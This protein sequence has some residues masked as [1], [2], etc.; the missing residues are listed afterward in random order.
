MDTT[1]ELVRVSAQ[2]IHA[3]AQQREKSLKL[4]E[5]K[6]CAAKQQIP[7]ELVGLYTR[8]ADAYS[9]YLTAFADSKA[10]AEHATEIRY[11]R[12]DILCFKLAKGEEAGDE[13]LAVGK[14]AP[15]GKLHKP[16]LQNAIDAFEAARP[17]DTQGKHQVYP[18][19]EKFGEALDLYATLFPGDP[20]IIGQIYKN[21]QMFFDYGD[22]DNAIKRFGVI[23]TRYPKDENA[24]PAGDKILAALGKAKDFENLETWARKLKTAPSFQS[25]DRQELLTKLIVESIQ[26]SG[27]KFSDAGKY[28]KAAKFYLRVPKET[29]DVKVASTAMMN[30][31]KVY[32]LA[33]KPED[34]ADVYL[35]V[36]EQYGDKD[37]ASARR[38]RSPPASSTSRCCSSTAPRRHRAR[39]QEVQHRQGH[40]AEKASDALYNAGVLRQ[41][42]GQNDKAIEHYRTTR[43][44][45]A[46]TPPT[47][48]STSVRCTKSRVKTALR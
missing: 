26:R 36:A 48:A 2:N 15:V 21:G 27:D 38:R 28:E 34:A 13:Y 22:Y 19:D 29:S 32:E 12:A 46:R 10:A 37:P 23:V 31:G 33:K 7:A 42:L 4:P 8:A 45:A 6:H 47:S 5:L 41:A 18:V 43:R 17:K 25:K 3:V 44:R 11:Y 9:E 39:R 40:R 24:G 30:A 20:A 1:E 35:D 14:T 16:A